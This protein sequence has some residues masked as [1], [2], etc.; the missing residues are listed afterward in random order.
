MVP[1]VPI[2]KVFKGIVVCG[3]LD[4]GLCFVESLKRKKI[5]KSTARKSVATYTAR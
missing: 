2:Q 4:S 1:A 3:I 5:H